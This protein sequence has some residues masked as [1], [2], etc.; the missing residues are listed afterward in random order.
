MLLLVPPHCEASMPLLAPAQLASHARNINYRFYTLDVNA[1]IRGDF[2]T[3][4]E[5]IHH[6]KSTAKRFNDL[7]SNPS[8]STY[9]NTIKKHRKALKDDLRFGQEASLTWDG[10]EISPEWNDIKAQY[11]FLSDR[12]A[13][14][15]WLAMCD[16]ICGFVKRKN[17]KIVGLSVTFLSQLFESLAIAQ[18]IRNKIPEI[19]IIFGGG[20][21]NTYIKSQ[22][23]IVGPLADIASL[24][25]VGDGELLISFLA[26]E[27]FRGL[28]SVSCKTQ[29]NALFLKTSWLSEKIEIPIVPSPLYLPKSSDKYLSPKV[30]LPYR[31]ASSCYWGKCTFCADHQYKTQLNEDIPL[32]LH[33]DR[34]EKFVNDS[35][36]Y[37]VCFLDSAI[38]PKTLQELAKGFIAR[39]LNI[40]WGTNVRFEKCFLNPG[41]LEDLFEGG[42]RFLRFGLESASQKVLNAM[43]KGTDVKIAGKILSRCRG[44]SILTHAYT[45][46]GFPGEVES[47]RLT[48][49]NFLLDSETHPDLFSISRFIEYPESIISKQLKIKKFKTAD[50]TKLIINRYIED[51]HID[52]QRKFGPSRVLVSPAHTIGMYDDT[53]NWPATFS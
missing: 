47:D 6:H 4:Q 5:D 23:D 8:P 32:S 26:K 17:L 9:W 43:G 37:G 24:I 45:M 35:S 21:I 15:A 49:R 11:K 28:S 1:D 14:D 22:D 46:T 33:L 10:V 20:V 52:F 50:T 44:V 39:G 16:R 51:L 48:T 29:G 40:Y 30:V 13:T 7:S 19:K 42:C 36:A 31:I 18:E 12:K 53:A 3:D 27:G 2:L 25:C 41:L 38:S 34:I